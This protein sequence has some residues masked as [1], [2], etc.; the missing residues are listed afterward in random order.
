MAVTSVKLGVARN[1]PATALSSV[2]VNVIE[3][4]SLADASAIVNFGS[5]RSMSTLHCCA[6]RLP[7]FA[8]FAA[9]FAA[10]SIV[11]VPVAVGVTE[12]V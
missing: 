7:R 11:S 8:P 2:T 6:A 4:P 12:A 3:S 9:T 5:S 10:T 1:P